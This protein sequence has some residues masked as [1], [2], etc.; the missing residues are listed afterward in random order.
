MKIAHG[1]RSR[2]VGC[3]S[4]SCFERLL[5]D[6]DK[7][8]RAHPAMADTMDTA[9][10]MIRPPIAWAVAVLTGLALNW[11]MPLPFVPAAVP[12]GRLGAIVF[13]LALALVAWAIA[14]IAR[15]GSNVPTSRPTTTIVDTGPYRFT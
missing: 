8:V 7:T 10:V 15:A 1:R 4:V 5:N 12:A 9:N 2:V 6:R 14:T 13:A 3:E 11:L